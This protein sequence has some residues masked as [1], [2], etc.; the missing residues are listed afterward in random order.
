MDSNGRP[1]KNNFTSKININNNNIEGVKDIIIENKPISQT[2]DD[3]KNQDEDILLRLQLL[4]NFKTLN[5][6][7][8]NT[9]Q[10]NILDLQNEN[11][12][13]KQIIYNLTGINY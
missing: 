6:L 1:I 3:F 2:I 9:I 10:S 12:K 4:E 8:I 5:E 7:Q 11:I 13:L